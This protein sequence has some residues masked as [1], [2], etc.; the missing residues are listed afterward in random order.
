MNRSTPL[1][2]AALVSSI[3][4]VSGYLLLQSGAQ[5]LPGSK[6]A[7]VALPATSPSTQPGGQTAGNVLGVLT[8]ESATSQPARK[9]FPGSKSNAVMRPENLTG[10]TF[11]DAPATQPAAG[12]AK[13]VKP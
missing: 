6:S 10:V 2:V 7:R 5:V 11:T 8:L 3:A 13:S 12:A 4:L 9:F 1:K